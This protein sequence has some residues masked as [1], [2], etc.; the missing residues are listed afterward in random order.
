VEGEYADACA[1][2]LME[3]GGGKGFRLKADV[4]A[5]MCGW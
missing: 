2:V 1:K 5:R 3:D 4:V